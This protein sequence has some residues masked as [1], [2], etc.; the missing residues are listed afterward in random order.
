LT[1]DDW[2]RIL[3]GGDWNGWNNRNQKRGFSAKIRLDRA[4]GDLE[5]GGVVK[6][7]TGPII[8]G[9]ITRDGHVLLHLLG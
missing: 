9:R 7:E 1:G 4:R 8:V 2:E 5:A 3:G 6:F